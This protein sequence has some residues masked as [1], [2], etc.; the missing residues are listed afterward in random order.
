MGTNSQPRADFGRSGGGWTAT[1][2]AQREMEGWWGWNSSKLQGR[3]W[4]AVNLEMH[5]VGQHAEHG[6]AVQV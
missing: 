6:P 3:V 2:T 1:Q 4:A 5:C